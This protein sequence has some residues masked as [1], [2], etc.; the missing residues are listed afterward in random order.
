MNYQN[1]LVELED[2]MGI[3]QI[4]R[5]EVRN[6]LDNETLSEID[7]AFDSL[8]NNKQI[9]VIIVT[10]T[11]EKSFAAGADIRQLSKKQPIDALFPG[12]SGLYRKIE[13]S[14][15]ATIAAI[16]GFALGGGCE[17]ALACDIRIAAED[18]KIGL[19]EL[20]LS[21]IPGA[22]GT[23][24]LA[25]IIGK[26]R[27]LDMILTGEIVTASQAQE[28][29]LVSS[30]VPLSELIQAA[31]EKADK[32]VKKG[33]L[34]IRMAKLVINRGFDI[35]MDTALMMEKMA[36]AIMFGSDD[37]NEGTQAFL[38]KRPALFTGK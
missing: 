19:P 3:I 11:G 18:A 7:H 21:I 30:V 34:A 14:S 1:I 37:K 29:G 13:N 24:R 8:E 22:G 15:K 17:L 38:E 25:R 20:S 23:Q 26:G 10:G 6:A 16:N 5:P 32:I 36:Q 27:A 28:I 35:D 31:K 2:R 9:G 12:M 33:P 4:N